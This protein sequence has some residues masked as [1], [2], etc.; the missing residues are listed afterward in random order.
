MTTH[1]PLVDLHV[2]TTASDGRLTPREVV[3]MAAEI[4]LS[5][6]AITDHDTLGGVEEA[7]AEGA[8]SGVTVVPGVELSV[9]VDFETPERRLTE[10]H[11]LVYHMRI[12]GLLAQKLREI[13]E[14]RGSR[15]ERLVERLGE[16]GMPVT[17]DEV[18]A[19]AKD[20]V[21]RPHFAAALVQ[22]GYVKDLDEAFE[23]YLGEGKPAFLQKKR[24]SA[25]EAIDL[26]RAEGAVPVLA[27]VGASP[28]LH[29]LRGLGDEVLQSA[30]KAWTARG[31]GGVEVEHPEQ[32]EACRTKL[33]RWAA[34]LDL[35]TTGGSDFHGAAKPSIALGSGRNGNVAVPASALEGLNRRHIQNSTTSA[36]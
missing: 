3:R 26:A 29:G 23:H 21:G 2:H 25:E 34:D 5:G 30:L 28:R 31:L 13:R 19:L 1:T 8:R 10:V 35:V 9:T 36:S 27:H 33:R 15:N 12:G 11:M 18:S 7:V 16:L 6:I 14:W 32:D 20:V 4:G 22:R 24:L 17:P